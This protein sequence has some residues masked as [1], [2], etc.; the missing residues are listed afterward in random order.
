MTSGLEDGTRIEPH[1]DGWVAIDRYGSFLTDPEDAS[2]IVDPD[3]EDMPLA[4]F[5]TAQAAYRAWEHSEKAA[6]ARAGRRRE[7]L[8][9]LGKADIR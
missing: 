5:P 3:D 2:W 6:K 4:V 8:R 1:G 7:A 9:R